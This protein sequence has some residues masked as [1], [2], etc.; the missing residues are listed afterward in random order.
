MEK[1]KRRNTKVK[2]AGNGEGSLYYSKAL[3]KWVYY[4]T[5]PNKTRKAI[6]QRK[7]ETV[8][9][10]KKRVIGIKSKIYNGNYISKSS[11]TFSSILINFYDR[12]LKDNVI[13]ESSYLIYQRII[14]IIRKKAK[15]FDYPIQKISVNDIENFKDSIRIYSNESINKIWGCLKIVFK[16][17]YFRRI[18]DY[19]IMLDETLKKPFS[20]KL[21]PKIEALNTEEE[22]SLIEK[23]EKSR[24]TYRYACLLQLYTGA[25]MGE[26]LA[27]CRDCIDLENNTL[28]IKRTITK[29]K[30]GKLRLSEHTK[31]YKITSNTDKG[32]RTFTM[33]PEV[34]KII[35]ALLD[36]KRKNPKGLLFWDK[37]KH[38]LISPNYINQFLK[39]L[40]KN[41]EITD[42]PL[43]TH[44]LRHTFIT[45]CVEC[46]MNLKAIQYLVGHIRGSSIT[47]DIY[48]TISDDF[49]KKELEKIG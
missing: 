36:R 30:N 41:S 23:L 34:L 5:E 46:G 17:A 4:Y 2:S 25:R 8:T 12:K 6:K 47:L 11:E 3:K 48:T 1:R 42:K 37:K 31:G 27:I 45:R 15:F 16:I 14:D 9:D 24:S 38:K 13:S 29:D 7:N 22:K 43:H 33:R 20:I 28:T 19:N 21:T 35:K 10:F 40:N 39:T 26:I 18:I 44:V 49:L 32:K